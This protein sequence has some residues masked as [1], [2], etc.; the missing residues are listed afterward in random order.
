VNVRRAA[1]QTL[2]NVVAAFAL[3]ST[4][5]AA[6]PIFREPF[7]LHLEVDEQHYYEEHFSKVPFV[8]RND[9]YLFKGDH[10]GISLGKD[11]TVEYA[12][13]IDRADLEFDFSQVKNKDGLMMLLVIRN[14]TSHIIA[15]DALMTVP[16]KKAIARTTIIPIGA[17]LSSY[18]SWPHPIVQLVV[19]NVHA[20]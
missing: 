2:R 12:K 3:F 6:E 15:M 11:G 14:R 5:E 1:N 4:A 10:F 9:I 19:R 8:D 7:T 16:G 20:Q 13:D 18:E 17:G